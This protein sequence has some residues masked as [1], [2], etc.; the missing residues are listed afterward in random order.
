MF[1][2][3]LLGLVGIKFGLLK[4]CPKLKHFLWLLFNGGIATAEFLHSIN[5]GPRRMC[6]LCNLDYES[7]EHLFHFCFKTQVFWAL[8]FTLL[9][10]QIQFPDGFVMGRWL[11]QLN[12]SL[13]VKSIIA[14][15]AWFLW[16]AR[17]DAIFRDV[18]PNFHII[19]HKAIS[20]AKDIYCAGIAS[21]KKLIISNFYNLDGPFL[22]STSVWNSINQVCKGGFFISSSNL[23]ISIAGCHVFTVDAHSDA[24]LSTL[25]TAL[26]LAINHHLRIQIIFVCDSNILGLLKSSNNA[27]S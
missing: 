12:Y 24:E 13:R 27:C 26:Q 8:I 9:S 23:S 1:L 2:S 10:K 25:I 20:R 11:T 14:L 4:S 6:I 22:F 21:C 19:A 3:L 5:L 17:C 16:N 18:K 7:S 15:S